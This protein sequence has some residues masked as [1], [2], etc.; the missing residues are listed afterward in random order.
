M[1]DISIRRLTEADM[2]DFRDIRQEASEKHP[3]YFGHSL[4]VT[5]KKVHKCCD[6]NRKGNAL[7]GAY[8]GNKLIGIAIVTRKQGGQFEHIATL[9]G[10][11]VREAFRGAGVGKKLVETCIEYA[12]TTAELLQLQMKVTTS[13]EKALHVYQSLG[14]AIYGTEKQAVKVQSGYNDEHLL[15]LTL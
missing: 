3:E 13:N 4:E 15:S 14:F 9:W 8:S 7:L 2:E 5:V 10:V 12:K 11:Y 1:S 6:V